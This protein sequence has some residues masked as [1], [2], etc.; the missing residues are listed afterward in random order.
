MGRNVTLDCFK[1]ILSIL[2]IAIH[3]QPLFAEESA[4]GWLIS[5]GI[6]RIAV[7]CFFIINGY[8]ISR[9]LDDSRAMRKYII[10][11]VVIY[12]VWSLIYLPTYVSDVAARSLITFALMGYYHLW[13]LPALIIGVLILWGMKK[14]V[15]N[16][17]VIL[18]VALALFLTGYIMES[19]DVKFRI[20][21]NGLFFGFPFIAIGY[22][23]KDQLI[24]NKIKAIPLIIVLIISTLTLLFESYTGYK[25]GMYRNMLLSLPFLCTGLIITALK[26]PKESINNG[27]ISKLAGSIYYIHILVLTSIIPLA[28]ANNISKLPSILI[29]SVLISIFIILINKRL[30]ILL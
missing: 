1:V 14:Y 28:D 27:Y 21:R 12:I 15:R 5:N 30:K 6:A 26:Y 4:T 20:F 9:K 8:Y 2:V 10:H 29:I 19:L 23:I 25:S 13:Y 3:C 22:Y 7:P 16:N 24:I 17:T 11:L 18:V